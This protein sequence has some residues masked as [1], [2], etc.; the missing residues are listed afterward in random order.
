ML[1]YKP[2][3]R[4]PLSHASG[5]HSIKLVFWDITPCTA[6]KLATF[7]FKAAL[8]TS[9]YS[10]IPQKTLVTLWQLQITHVP[11][12]EELLSV[13][14][15]FHATERKLHTFTTNDEWWNY[16]VYMYKKSYIINNHAE[17]V[18]YMSLILTIYI[19]QETTGPRNTTKKDRNIY[20]NDLF[21][22]IH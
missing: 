2:L 6:W 5:K 7:T 10:V 14:N 18:I 1:T 15:V 19:N 22:K 9:A 11:Q 12:T 21:Q 13:V 17:N 3:A 20:D 16:K 4:W 8:I